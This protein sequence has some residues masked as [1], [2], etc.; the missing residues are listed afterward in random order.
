[1][2]A[3]LAEHNRLR[4]AVRFQPHGRNRGYNISYFRYKAGSVPRNNTSCGN[5]PEADAQQAMADQLTPFVQE[6]LGWA[7]SKTDD[8]DG[9]NAAVSYLLLDSR[10]IA[11]VSPADLPLVLAKLQKDKANPV[12][13]EDRPWEKLIN[14]GYPNVFFDKEAGLFK[15]WY[16]CQTDCPQRTTEC[17]H[18]S[19]NHSSAAGEVLHSESVGNGAQTGTCYATS[20]DGVE[21]QKPILGAIA[22]NHS[23]V[24]NLVMLTRADNGRGFLKDSAA[25]D[26]NQ[27][28]KM[29]GQILPFCLQNISTGECVHD[30]GDGNTVARALGTSTSHDGIHWRPNVSVAAMVN[31]AGDASIQLLYDVAAG[32]YVGITRID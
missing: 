3:N 18:R 4:R 2:A 24:N 29:F 8:G 21:W 32:G 26:P 19:W 17:P 12:L 25:S 16:G 9:E 20:I 27:R 7:P 31:A 5:H 30:S 10:N 23:T 13:K 6:L 15:M 22:W 11:S 1:M 28:Y 14:S